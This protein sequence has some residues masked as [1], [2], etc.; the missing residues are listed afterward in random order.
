MR[1]RLRQLLPLLVLTTAGCGSMFGQFKG[2][3]ADEGSGDG[4]SETGPIDQ[5]TEGNETGTTE[6]GD[7]TGGEL[8][9]VDCEE[10]GELASTEGQQPTEIT[11]D[12]VSGE[13]RNAFRLD[14]NGERVDQAVIEPDTQ[15]VQETYVE[16]P[17]VVTDDKGSCLMIFVPTLDPHVIPL[18]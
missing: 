14:E 13:V 9:F 11:W 5:D 18:E 12:N 3:G 17:W 7:E 8:P 16:H 10:E 2:D 6:S 4:G 15:V 1:R